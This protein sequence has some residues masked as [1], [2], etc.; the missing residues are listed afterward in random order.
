M[1]GGEKRDNG[2][3]KHLWLPGVNYANPVLKSNREEGGCQGHC[4]CGDT[5]GSPGRHFSF[6]NLLSM[7]RGNG[8]AAAVCHHEG[9]ASV[10]PNTISRDSML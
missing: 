4:T 7:C 6:D 3:S 5:L 2:P 9:E 8:M 1:W 10:T